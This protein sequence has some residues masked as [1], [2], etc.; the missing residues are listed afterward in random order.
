MDI[1]ETISTRRSV[2]RFKSAPISREIVEKLIELGNWA[3]SNCNLQ[4]WR[5]I[6][7]DDM[8][9]KQQIVDHGGSLIIKTAPLGILVCYDHR[10][11]NFEYNDWLQSAAAAVQNILLGAHAMGIGCCWICH[12]PRHKILRTLFKIPNCYTPVAYLAIGYPLDQDKIV[13]RHHRVRDL[14]EYNCFPRLT[15]INN[16]NTFFL[17]KRIT[18]RCYYSLPLFLKKRV[19]NFINRYFIKKFE[20]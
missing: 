8:G 4:G 20:N 6:I 11:D 17:W 19:N 13:K 5:F 2:R 1:F 7:V 12:L 14:Y 16:R 3:P 10:S 15:N 9:L 18:R